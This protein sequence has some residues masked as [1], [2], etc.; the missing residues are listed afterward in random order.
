MCRKFN[1]LTK[2]ADFYK[3][4]KLSDECCSLPT[5]QVLAQMLNKSGSK[6]K[7]IVCSYKCEYLLYVAVA[8]CRDTIREIHVED[9]GS[10]RRLDIAS[11]MMRDIDRLNPKSLVNIRFKNITFTLSRKMGNEPGWGW[12]SDTSHMVDLNVPPFLYAINKSVSYQFIIMKIR[13]HWRS[14]VQL[15]TAQDTLCMQASNTSSINEF[16]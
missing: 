2:V 14:K 16:M 8:N 1:E 15:N 5:P 6:L 10:I 4:I 13:C 3:E 9:F 12:R 7:K 11:N